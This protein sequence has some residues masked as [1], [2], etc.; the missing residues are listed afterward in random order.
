MGDIYRHI[1]PTGTGGV[2]PRSHLLLG[3]GDRFKKE[4]ICELS[5]E[6]QFKK[7]V[8]VDIHGSPDIWWDLNEFPYPF[9]DE[10]FDEIHAYEVL[11][12]L[13]T[14]GDYKYFF[15]QFNEL[16]RILVPGGV[17]CASVPSQD[18]IW[19]WGDPGHTRVLPMAVFGF[20]TEKIYEGVGKGPTQDYRD[21]IDGFWE[22]EGHQDIGHR[23]YFVLRKPA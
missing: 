1:Q 13:G 2:R 20:L 17:F 21:Y 16:R 12:H 14:Q 9:H 19:A 18:S 5:P 4:V 15:E 11:E 8:T 7:V 6:K 23:I 3:A 10:E 22:F